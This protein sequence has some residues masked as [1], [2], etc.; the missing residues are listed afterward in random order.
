[1]P[2]QRA[3]SHSALSLIIEYNKNNNNNKKTARDKQQITND[4]HNQLLCKWISD[5]S[6]LVWY[7]VFP[8]LISIRATCVLLAEILYSR[9]FFPICLSD[10]MTHAINQIKQNADFYHSFVPC[11]YVLFCSQTHCAQSN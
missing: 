8:K 7:S 2:C 3:L 5:K 4:I 11:F 9:F 1:M 6:F 10:K